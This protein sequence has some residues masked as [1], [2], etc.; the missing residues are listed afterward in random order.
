MDIGDTI[1]FYGNALLNDAERIFRPG[2][3]HNLQVSFGLM[4]RL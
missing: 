3:E 1:I 4:F 2:T